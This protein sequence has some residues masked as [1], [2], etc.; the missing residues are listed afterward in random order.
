MATGI[1]T[2]PA[3]GVMAT[4][5]TTAPIQK[6]MADTFFPRATSNNIH[7]SPAE[8]AAKFVVANAMAAKGD[9]PTAEPAL[10]PNQ[11]NHNKPVPSNT[12]GMLA[13]GK[14]LPSVWAFLLLR[15]KAPAK[16][17]QPALMCTTV[18]PAKSRTPN[19]KKYPSGCHV[20]WARGEYT[21]KLNKI[22][23][24]T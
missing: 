21:N 23:N 1:V 24:N 20:M 12:N 3:A 16:A 6:P 8:A 9:A 14:K 2:N 10:N 5:P 22:M 11:P 13:G 17:A 18:P 7:D 19:L 4:K 15:Y